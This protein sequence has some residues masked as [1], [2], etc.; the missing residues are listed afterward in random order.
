MTS[1]GPYAA[2]RPS[3]GSILHPPEVTLLVQ[4]V[5]SFIPQLEQCSYLRERGEEAAEQIVRADG[6][7][8]KKHRL[9]QTYRMIDGR[10]SLRV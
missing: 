6:R 4:F 10:G 7:A 2:G 5:E 9:R 3:L 1:H 8:R